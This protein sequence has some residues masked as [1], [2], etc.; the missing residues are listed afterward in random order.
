MEQGDL[1]TNHFPWVE[2]LGQFP[3]G[4][5]GSGFNIDRHIIG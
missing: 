5:G 2:D 3:Q 1:T 4:E